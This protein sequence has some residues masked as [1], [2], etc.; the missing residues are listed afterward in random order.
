MIQRKIPLIAA[1]LLCFFQPQFFAQGGADSEDSE[2]INAQFDD[3]DSLFD[4]AEDVFAPIVTEEKSPTGSY[5]IPIGTLKLPIEV[6]G[7]LD[8]ELGLA[9]RR[10]DGSNDA[11]VY[12]DFQNY[13]YFTTRPDKYLALKAVVKTQMPDSDDITEAAEDGQ[14]NYFYIYE[15]YFDYLMFDRI[16]I[17]AG[18]KKSVWGNI[19]LFSNTDDYENDTDA[20]Y[21]NILYDSR[22]HISGI[23]K[24]PIGNHTFTAIG[25]Y[26]GGGD[27]AGTKDMSFAASAEFVFFNTSINFFGRRFPLAYGSNSDQHQLPILGVELKRTILGFDLYAQ[28]LTRVVSGKNF[29]NFFKSKFE[30]RDVFNKIIS[31][32]GVY[33]IWN[34]NTPYFGFNFEFQNIYRRHRDEDMD[35][36]TNRFALY[37]GVAKL[38]PKK[39]I[40]IGFQWN[41]NITDNS[42]FIKSGVIISSF[43]PHCDWRNG[44]ECKYGADF[45]SYKLT[46]GSYLRI[47][48]DY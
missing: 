40:G 30:D 7:D 37:C 21:T 12:F 9:F 22:I 15:M 45:D 32:A 42:G 6:S 34:E 5:N 48:L 20:L 2:D 33:R 38:G 11:T 3:F 8:A 35:K 47:S 10:E 41:H 28:E 25:M 13:I 17:T 18:K 19:R 16:Y 39:D 43:L 24:I 31:T 1:G 27:S 14:T 44:F 46:V 23:V 36:F 26:K 29:L 4:D